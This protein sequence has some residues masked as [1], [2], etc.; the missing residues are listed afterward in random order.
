MAKR[1]FQTL[2]KQTGQNC[3]KDAK[4]AYLQI[5][6]QTAKQTARKARSYMRAYMEDSG[7]SH[8]LT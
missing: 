6:L 8:F 4:K 2:N 7:G 3:E 1:H 5:T